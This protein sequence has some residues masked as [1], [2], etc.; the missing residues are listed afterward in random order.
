MAPF[1]HWQ[2]LVSGWRS[3]AFAMIAISLGLGATTGG[4]A[5]QLC[6]VQK[7]VYIITNLGSYVGTAVPDNLFGEELEAFGRYFARMLFSPSLKENTPELLGT[8]SETAKQHFLQFLDTGVARRL[9][10]EDEYYRPH[11]TLGDIT[12]DGEKDQ[13]SVAYQ[14]RIDAPDNGSYLGALETQGT[15]LLAIKKRGVAYRKKKNV[16]GMEVMA[17]KFQEKKS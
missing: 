11:L 14:L 1:L 17:L 5:W 3:V 7:Q 2:K 4:L 15:L 16:F 6:Q 9:L 12:Y 8:L 13:L 10:A